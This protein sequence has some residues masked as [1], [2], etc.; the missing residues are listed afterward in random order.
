MG[1]V[2]QQRI[3]DAWVPLSFFS[4]KLLETEKKYSAFDRE[5]LAAYL[6]IRHF[7]F[8]LE[9][10]D[11]LLFTDHKPL[12]SALFRSS[13][14][15]SARQKR[16]LAYIAEFMSSIVHVPGLENTVADAFSRPSLSPVQPSPVFLPVVPSPSG[17]PCVPPRPRPAPVSPS[18]LQPS[19]P[20][21]ALVSP[22]L[23]PSVSSYAV[24]NPSPPR[25]LASEV[26]AVSAVS[27]VS[28][29][30]PSS[31]SINQLNSQD[32]SVPGFDFSHILLLQK[33]CPSIEV[34]RSLPSLSKVNVTLD[35]GDLICD[36]S[37]GSLRP[38]VPEVLC[39]PLFLALHNVSLILESEV[40]IGSSPPVLSGLDCL[41]MSGCGLDPVSGVNRAR[42]RLM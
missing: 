34:M 8:M 36:D 27:A 25:G 29:S 31:P 10:R 20:F 18:P 5:L 23:Q 42:F 38:L 17:S 28:D 4:R 22:T 19:L 24:P 40:H 26:S 3:D 32:F 12:T 39:K 35:S 11:F 16:H 21:H 2:L 14:P 30:L 1:A 37:T 41:V 6:S 33:T 7:R 13:P 9:G 15:W